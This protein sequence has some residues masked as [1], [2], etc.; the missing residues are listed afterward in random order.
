MSA[1][2]HTSISSWM[3]DELPTTAQLLNLAMLRLAKEPNSIFLGQ[4]VAFPGWAYSSLDGV[5]MSQRIE[6]PVAEEL[7]MGISTGL[8]LQGY[9][10]VSFYPRMDFLLLAAN[11]LINHLDKLQEMSRGSFK[12]KVIIRT[13]V[14]PNEPL[15]AGPQH[16]QCHTSAFQK[17]LTNMLVW[18][19]TKKKDITW[20]YNEAVNESRSVMIVERLE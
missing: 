10:P 8:A 11:Q 6:M 19:L 3:P 15:N 2:A 7:Q 14:G 16:T 18:S 17:M 1:P 20:M 4:S 13:R 9:L 5:P 12:P